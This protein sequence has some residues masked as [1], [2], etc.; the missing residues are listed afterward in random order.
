MRVAVFAGSSMGSSPGFAERTVSFAQELV[1]ARAG[2]VYGGG[3]IGLMG[4]LADAALG[5]GG[6]VIGVMPR[7][8]VDREIGHREVSRLEIVENMHE[9]KARMAALADAFVALPGGM[10][11]LEELF[12]VW[13]WQ[14]LGLHAKPVGLLDV[15][16]FWTPLLAALD[17]LVDTGFVSRASRDTLFVVQDAGELLA[18]VETWRPPTVSWPVASQGTAPNSYRVE[19]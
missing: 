18:A 8:L 9:R 6:E 12:E 1:A 14:Q 16:G 4:V 5:A 19:R 3:H 7:F 11:T 10:G 2:V 17:H 13:T 15:A